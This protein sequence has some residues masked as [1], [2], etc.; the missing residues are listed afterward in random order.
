MEKLKQERE[1]AEKPESVLH[2]AATI[3]DAVFPANG[4][5]ARIDRKLPR[6]I[7]GQLKNLAKGMKK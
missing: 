5:P 2:N 6:R 3:L 7:V 1:L 4:E